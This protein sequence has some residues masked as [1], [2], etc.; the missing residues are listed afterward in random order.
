MPEPKVDLSPDQSKIS[1]LASEK[2]SL[3]FDFPSSATDIRL[4]LEG[5]SLIKPDPASYDQLVLIPD[6]QPESLFLKALF[7]LDDPKSIWVANFSDDFWHVTPVDT[8]HPE[9]NLPSQD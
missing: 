9:L 8:D 7:C 6:H 3:G 4:F 5:N 2:Q 1:L